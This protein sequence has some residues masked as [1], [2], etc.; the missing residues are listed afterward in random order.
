MWKM[1]PIAK[2]MTDPGEEYYLANCG[3]QVSEYEDE[4]TISVDQ[5]VSGPSMSSGLLLTLYQQ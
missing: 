1:S 5:E 4:V 2:L 3:G